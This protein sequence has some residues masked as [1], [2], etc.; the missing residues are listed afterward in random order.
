MTDVEINAWTDAEFLSL[1]K[2]H[3]IKVSIGESDRKTVDLRVSPTPV[4]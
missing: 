4:Y 1:A 2:E 3:A